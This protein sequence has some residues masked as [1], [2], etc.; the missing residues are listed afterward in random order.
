MAP[1]LALPEAEHEQ[2]PN[3]PLKLMLGQLRYPAVLRVAQH[4][5]LAAFQDA[6]RELYPDYAEDQQL[7]LALGPQGIA[8]STEALRNYRFSTPDRAWSVVVNPASVTLE[9]TVATQYTHYGEFR[10]RF[11]QVWEVALER[12]GVTRIDYQGL[13]Y[14]D[15]LDW[16]DVGASDWSRYVDASLLGPLGVDE[17]QGRVVHTLT[18]CRLDLQEDTMISFKYGLVNTGPEGR[19]GFLMDTD[20]AIQRTTGEVGVHEMLVR[21]DALHEEI[22]NLFSWATTEEA[23]ERFRGNRAASD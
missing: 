14:I 4:A 22:H 18:D 21:F 2:F 10:D 13:R 8:A 16:D 17:L 3:P 9:A 1:V 19:I 11:A 20:A 5:E 7:N 6:I 15:H 12:F 23:R